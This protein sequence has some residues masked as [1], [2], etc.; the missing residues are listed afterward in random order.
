MKFKNSIYE[1]TMD[2]WSLSPSGKARTGR[3]YRK[4]IEFD[5]SRWIRLVREIRRKMP[6]ILYFP[7]F[8]FEFP[9]RIYLT[10]D[11][12]ETPTNAYYRLIVQDVLDSIDDGLTIE[13]HIVERAREDNPSSRSAP[14]AVLLKMG[15]V[16][17]RTIF[18]A[19][20]NMFG[21]NI[22]TREIIVRCYTEHVQESEEPPLVYLEFS[23]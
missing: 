18:V 2:M 17:S 21:K 5:K 4:L 15:T 3:K 9:Q 23:I 12:N 13:Q 22:Q 1:A 10:E 7:T 19:W 6:S 8:L 11:S 20:N 16:V 14:E